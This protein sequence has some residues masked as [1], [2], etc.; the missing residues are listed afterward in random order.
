MAAY[1]FF[2]HETITPQQILTPHYETTLERIKKEQSV[3]ILQDTTE[4]DFSG[5]KSLAGIGYL[6]NEKSQGFYLHPNLAI[7]PEK[8]CLGLVNTEIWQRARTRH[9]RTKER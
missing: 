3:L 1:R 4:I 9:S 5:R 8:L 6:G 2:N 7:T